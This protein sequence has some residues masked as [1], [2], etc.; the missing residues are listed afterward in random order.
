MPSA[1]YWQK[2]SE[3]LAQRQFD[4]ADQYVGELNKEYQRA[5]QEIRRNIEVFYQR[6][7]DNN[8]I[9]LAEARKKLGGK[10]LTEF[11]M[12]LEEFI[13]KAKNN[14]DGRWTRDLNNTYYRTRVSRLEALQTQ[15]RQQ[16]EMLTESRQKG[17]QALLGGIYEDTY[18]RTIYEIQK[19]IGL[20][21]S[22]ASIDQQGLK[23]VLKTEF[24]GANYSKRIWDDRDRLVREL[25]TKL[26][27]SFIRGDSID[28]TISDMTERMNVSR[29]NAARLVQT[30]SSFFA[31][32]A[33]MAGYKASKVVQKYEVLAT[34]DKR[35]SEICRSMDGKVFNL[36]EAEVNVNYPPFHVRCRTTVVPYFDDEID[37]GERIARDDED[38]VYYVPGDMTYKAWYDKHTGGTGKGETSPAGNRLDLKPIERLQLAEVDKKLIEYEDRIRNEPIEHAYAITEKGEVYHSIGTEGNVQID[39]IGITNL[40][41]SRVTHNHPSPYGDPGGSFSRD[42]IIKFFACSLLEL[43]AVDSKYRYTLKR[44]KEIMLTPG[45]V[46]SLLIQANYDFRSKTTIWDLED[47]YDDKHLTMEEFVLL[48]DGLFYKREPLT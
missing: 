5:I 31:N 8:E 17:A 43:R 19:G 25:Q 12:T 34:L 39:A 35:T 32:Q 30:E 44:E 2:R 48:V 21:V 15:I 40:R 3:Q 23:T 37:A 42:D 7:A 9:S 14:Q 28:R 27:Q 41:N 45:E 22:F 38:N 47:G 13:A 29:T 18:Y 26:T 16:V 1:E 6:Y 46:G 36:N 11:K 10:E 20:G 4:K 33:T 24:A